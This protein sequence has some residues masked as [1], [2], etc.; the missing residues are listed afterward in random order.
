M[1]ERKMVVTTIRIEAETL[2]EARHAL[3]L[4]GLSVAKFVTQ[5]LEEVVREHRKNRPQQSQAP[6]EGG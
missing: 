6:D 5:K 1:A 4:Q 3:N 2:Y